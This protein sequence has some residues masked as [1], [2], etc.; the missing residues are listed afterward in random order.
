MCLMGCVLVLWEMEPRQHKA[1]SVNMYHQMPPIRSKCDWLDAL[2]TPEGTIKHIKRTISCYNTS[3]L[4]ILKSMS[5]DS[6]RNV[7]N[8]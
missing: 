4:M 8:V 5:H 7:Y 1:S 2:K 3:H 6:D